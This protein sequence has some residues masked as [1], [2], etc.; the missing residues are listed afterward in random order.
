MLFRSDYNGYTNRSANTGQPAASHRTEPITTYSQHSH[1]EAPPGVRSQESLNEEDQIQNNSE[2]QNL[3]NQKEKL[4]LS[5]NFQNYL[6]T[7]NQN[8]G[9][10][11]SPSQEL[12]ENMVPVN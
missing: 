10:E 9:S 2:F 8:D 11:N 5:E 12:V 7:K 4:D 3:N 6:F 1:S